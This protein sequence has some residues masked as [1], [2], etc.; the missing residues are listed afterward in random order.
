MQPLPRTWF[1][2]P[3]VVNM[4]AKLQVSPYHILVR[5][6]YMDGRFADNLSVKMYHVTDQSLQQAEGHQKGTS[7]SSSSWQ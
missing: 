5:D 6:K 7:S 1:T 4:S 3:E 2:W